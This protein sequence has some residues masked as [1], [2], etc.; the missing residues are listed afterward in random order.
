MELL[1]HTSTQTLSMKIYPVFEYHKLQEWSQN[2]P[3]LSLIL[4][5]TPPIGQFT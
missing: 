1:A 5:T 4:S 2:H 3:H